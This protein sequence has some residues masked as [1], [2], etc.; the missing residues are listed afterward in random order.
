MLA[1]CSSCNKLRDDLSCIS[2]RPKI[3]LP[4]IAAFSLSLQHGPVNAATRCECS[5][6]GF[7]TKGTQMLIPKIPSRSPL[8]AASIAAFALLLPAVNPVLAD[9]NSPSSVPTATSCFQA[10]RHDQSLHEVACDRS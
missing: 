2:L 6:G 10:D 1:K 9:D 7:T 4:C 8:L 3:N 5:P